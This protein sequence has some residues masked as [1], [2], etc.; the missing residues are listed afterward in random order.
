MPTGGLARQVRSATAA[1]ASTSEPGE[2]ADNKG[3]PKRAGA[4]EMNRLFELITALP[5]IQTATG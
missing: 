2:H 5:P 1:Y 4:E 3:V